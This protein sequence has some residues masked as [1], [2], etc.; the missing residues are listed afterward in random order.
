MLRYKNLQTSQ[1]LCPVVK[2]FLFV[3]AISFLALFSFLCA[4]QIKF[5]RWP[6]VLMG[7]CPS[8]AISIT[9]IIL[10]PP[11]FFPKAT[12]GLAHWVHV[13]KLD[14]PGQIPQ[15]PQLLLLLLL[16]FVRYLYICIAH[17]YVTYIHA[18]YCPH[19][20][21][22]RCANW[23]W[24]ANFKSL[25][26]QREA[27]LLSGPSASREQEGDWHRKRAREQQ[28]QQILLRHADKLFRRCYQCEA[29]LWHCFAFWLLLF[30]YVCENHVYFVFQLLSHKA[31]HTQGNTHIYTQ[32]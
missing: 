27:S 24:I 30:S 6:T 15:L 28:Q 1:I 12:A 23:N 11:P 31:R 17:I 5:M 32:Q 29:E 2:C 22:V 19:A 21:H 25:W 18:T 4:T 9:D 7:R 10:S 26:P 8:Q 3:S 20:A 13:L 16:L 14:L